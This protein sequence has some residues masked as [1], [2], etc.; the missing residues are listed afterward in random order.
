ERGTM[1]TVE[2][3]SFA[4]VLE[5]TMHGRVLGTSA[6]RAGS[7]LTQ[8]KEPFTTKASPLY[9]RERILDGSDA[10]LGVQNDT[11]LANEPSGPFGCVGLSN[12][13]NNCSVRHSKSMHPKASWLF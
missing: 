13:P 9:Q 7:R 2:E 5:T 4:S 3:I 1:V 11:H 12:Q 8:T 10:T 6:P